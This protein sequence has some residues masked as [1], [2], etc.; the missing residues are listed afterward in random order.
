M[1]EVEKLKKGACFWINTIGFIVLRK[2]EL[3]KLN[4]LTPD[5]FN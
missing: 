3:V 2:M 4:I 5:N 1:R